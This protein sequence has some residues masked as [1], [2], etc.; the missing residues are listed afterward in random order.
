MKSADPLDA[1][2]RAIGQ[3]ISRLV[4]TSVLHS[5]SGD[6]NG[7]ILAAGREF[8]MLSRMLIMPGVEE[9]VQIIGVNLNLLIVRPR[10]SMV[11]QG[12]H[13]MNAPGIL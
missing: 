7:L 3:V 5:R 13:I 2:N 4:F 1:F 12:S 6:N 11:L 10:G 9:P 8:M